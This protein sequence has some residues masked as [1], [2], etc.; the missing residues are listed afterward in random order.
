MAV[1]ALADESAHFA[2][3]DLAGKT[4]RLADYRGK[5]VIVNYWATWC[6]PCL[7]EMPELV[8]MY[9]ARKSQD[10]MVLGIAVDA[11]QA[12]EVLK[13]ADDMLVSYPIILGNDAVTKQIGGAE[14]LPT[15]YIYNPRGQLVEIKRGLITKQYIEGVMGLAKPALKR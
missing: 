14:V 1:P 10:V 9:D 2:L 15:T 13:F 4:H 12:K 6:P 5:W 3:T 8:A 11:D 7:E